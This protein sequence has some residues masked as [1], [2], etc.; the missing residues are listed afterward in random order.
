MENT[1]PSFCR[2]RRSSL[3]QRPRPNDQVVRREQPEPNAL[4]AIRN[5][6]HRHCQPLDGARGSPRERRLCCQ[7][8]QATVSGRGRNV[9][10]CRHRGG[11]PDEQSHPHPVATH[12]HHPRPPADDTGRTECLHHAHLRVCR[13]WLHQGRR[14]DFNK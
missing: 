1:T 8:L 7:V 3:C 11:Q 14:P 2:R 12:H 5:A 10:R 9:G 6:G 4:A 13:L